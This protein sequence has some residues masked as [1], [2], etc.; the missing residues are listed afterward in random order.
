MLEVWEEVLGL[1]EKMYEV[2]FENTDSSVL[3]T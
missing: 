3:K 2:V 1:E